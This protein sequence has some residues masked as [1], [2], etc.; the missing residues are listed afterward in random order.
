MNVRGRSVFNT[1][2]S[3]K[4]KKG[5][6][7]PTNK[8]VETSKNKL[9]NASEAL[10]GRWRVK[11]HKIFRIRAFGVFVGS[12]RGCLWR[13][14]KKTK[15]KFKIVEGI[16]SHSSKWMRFSKGGKKNGLWNDSVIYN[17]ACLIRVL[18]HCT[19]IHRVNQI[20]REL[21]SAIKQL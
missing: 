15:K 5:Q 8:S 18:W 4:T 10:M 20:V 2:D 9:P 14:S 13:G 12:T 17:K 3:S 19:S 1:F 6:K 11:N 21:L 7:R 16:F